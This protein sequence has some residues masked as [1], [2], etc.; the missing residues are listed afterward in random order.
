MDEGH[1]P[2]WDVDPQV[3]H[4]LNKPL[5]VTA[6]RALEAA[7]P[8]TLGHSLQQKHKQGEREPGLV[9]LS[10][11]GAHGMREGEGSYLE[12]GPVEPGVVAGWAHHGAVR[13]AVTHRLHADD[14]GRVLRWRCLHWLVWEVLP[15]EGPGGRWEGWA[16]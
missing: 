13:P 4:F 9:R 8:S 3:D 12:A 1:Q 10:A 5:S 2:D 14:A 16:R 6:E 11:C 7:Q 15:A